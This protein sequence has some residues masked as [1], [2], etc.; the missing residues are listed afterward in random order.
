MNRLPFRNR[1][2]AGRL[3][4]AELAKMALP[5]PFVLAL[6]RG[7]VP[8]GFEIAR[9]LDAPL[10]V[11][12]VRKIGVPWQPELAMGA[13]AGDSF[14]LLDFAI[15][16][17]LGISRD[18]MDRVIALEREELKRREMLYR[19]RRGAPDL[20]SKTAILVDDGLATGSTMLVAMRYVRSLA[21][22]KIVVAVP[23]ASIQASALVAEEAD[24]MAC[25]ATPEPF[26]A[27]GEWYLNFAQTSDAEVK[28]L[29]EESRGAARS[30]RSHEMR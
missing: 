21:P 24:T 7:G 6:A 23:V 29:L 1:F 3:L 20:H 28:M 27:V 14:E 22:L 5:E 25:L 15:I 16:R 10:D 13:I 11:V 26:S 18:Q 8:V 4:S 19:G 30:A 12:V 17:Q 9:S 2:E